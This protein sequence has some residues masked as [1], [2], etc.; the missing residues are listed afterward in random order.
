MA[1]P[2][3]STGVLNEDG[4]AHRTKAELAAR[5]QAEKAF[6]TGKPMRERLEVRKNSVAH[7][8]FV[9]VNRLLKQVGRG[10]AL[11]ET[12]INRYCMLQAECR[13]FETMREQFAQDLASMREDTE[14][15]ADAK[16]GLSVKMQQAI[17]NVDKQAQAKRKMMLDIEKECAMTISS[18]L[19]AI[20]KAP[21]PAENPLAAILADDD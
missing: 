2:S 10:D 6:A 7:Q 21:P 4:R 1:R 13:E 14:L 9:R 3:H 8:E 18:A 15:D 19:R 16:W 11:F 5:E 20:P 17:L 12:V